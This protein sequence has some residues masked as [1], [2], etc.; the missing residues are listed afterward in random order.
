VR[1][2]AAC[3][4]LVA[5]TVERFSSLEILV[6]NAGLGLYG[7]IAEGDPE[8]WRRM[9]DVKISFRKHKNILNSTSAP[10]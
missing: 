8:A 1:D 5:R 2:P 7:A 3:A 10:C 4:A 6:N 9:F